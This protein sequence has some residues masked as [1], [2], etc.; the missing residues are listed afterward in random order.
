MNVQE[1][2]VVYFSNSGGGNGNSVLHI[3]A[4][5]LPVCGR[6]PDTS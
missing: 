5:A 6:C 1:V 2:L 3:F 4:A